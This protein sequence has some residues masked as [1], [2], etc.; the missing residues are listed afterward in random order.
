MANIQLRELS[1]EE[2][3]K[4]IE[5]CLERLRRTHVEAKIKEVEQKIFNSE[6]KSQ[7][8]LMRDRKALIN[9]LNNPLRLRS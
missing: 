4:Q 1:V 3:A 9:A 7:I 8:K 2:P 6:P 5:F